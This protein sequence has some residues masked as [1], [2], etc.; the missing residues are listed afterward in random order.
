[1]MIQQIS[2]V[3]FHHCTWGLKMVLFGYLR[4]LWGEVSWKGCLEDGIWE[5]N[6]QHDLWIFVHCKILPTLSVFYGLLVEDLS[7][8]SSYAFTDKVW[9]HGEQMICRFLEVLVRGWGYG[10]IRYG[11]PFLV[12]LNLDDWMTDWPSLGWGWK[13]EPRRYKHEDEAWGLG[14]AAARVTLKEPSRK[15]CPRSEPWFQNHAKFINLGTMARNWALHAFVIS[16]KSLW[17]A[18]CSTITTVMCGIYIRHN[19]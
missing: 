11:R 4:M 17:S 12:E 1:M 19:L 2:H 16:F 3:F 8:S 5:A 15:Q 10:A 14:Q 13:I 9:K 7:E 18:G 6:F